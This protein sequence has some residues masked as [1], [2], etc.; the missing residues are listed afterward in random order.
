MCSPIFLENYTIILVVHRFSSLFIFSIHTFFIFLFFFFSFFSPPHFSYLSS[1]LLFSFISLFLGLKMLK[2]S[3]A[4]TKMHDLCHNSPHS[5]LW[6]KLYI[7]LW[8]QTFSKTLK[9]D[10]IFFKGKS[11]LC[12]T[13]EKKNRLRLLSSPDIVDQIL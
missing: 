10:I 8:H 4:T 11:P 5:K 6:H 3:N 1:F 12:S 2:K 9:H 7:F 13:K